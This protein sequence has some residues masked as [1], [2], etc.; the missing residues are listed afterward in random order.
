MTGRVLLLLAA[1]LAPAVPAV[2]ATIDGVAASV[3]GEII[4]I[5]ELEKAAQPLVEKRL[6]TAPERERAKVKREVLTN[7]LDKLVLRQ[8][9]LQR[10]EATGIRIDEAELNA[11]IANIMEQGSLTEEMLARALVEEGLTREEY[12]EQISDQILFSKLMQREIRARVAV[13]H[14]ELEEY[15]QEHEEEYYQPEQIRVRHLLIM[16]GSGPG[17]HEV[18]EARRKALD[19]LHKYREGADFSDLV[20]EYSPATT[21]EGETVSGWLKRGEFLK[22][23][24]EVAFSLPEGKVSE[25]IR[26]QAGFHLIQVAER[27]NAAYLS[28]ET[29]TD[30]ITEIITRQKMERDYQSWLDDLK[31]DAQVDILF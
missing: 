5:L 4:T 29:M 18:Q 2:A 28:L 16:V 14:E 26:S 31:E 27:R 19:I 20:K 30:S 8:I 11:A 17:A 24:E 21:S 3:N 23:L 13:T 22:E 1:L 7:V 6:L 25:P 10:A 15:Y 12:R 9:Q